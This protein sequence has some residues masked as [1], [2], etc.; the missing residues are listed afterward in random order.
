MGEQPGPFTVTDLFDLP[1]DPARLTGAASAL[2][3]LAARLED[4]AR[5][6]SRGQVSLGEILERLDVPSLS[7]PGTLTFYPFD[8]GDVLKVTAA[9]QAA[10]Q[11]RATVLVARDCAVLHANPPNSVQ[12]CAGA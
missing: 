11:I 10:A 2:R 12:K 6:L 7:G 8:A 3:V 5:L 4:A 1:G 9:L